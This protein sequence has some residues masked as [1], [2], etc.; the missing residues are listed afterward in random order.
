MIRFDDKND[1]SPAIQKLYGLKVVQTNNEFDYFSSN[2]KP[3]HLTYWFR[4]MATTGMPILQLEYKLNKENNQFVLFVEKPTI[5]EIP[6]TNDGWFTPLRFNAFSTLKNERIEHLLEDMPEIPHM[7]KFESLKQLVT[8]LYSNWALE[9]QQ[10]H[11]YGEKIG[12]N[13]EFRIVAPTRKPLIGLEFK[14]D[15]TGYSL[16][17]QYSLLNF[18]E[19]Y[20]PQ[21]ITL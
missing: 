9:V 18:E 15:K 4:V 7:P 2:P 12:G 13:I 11:W 10:L 3:N 17:R 6:K 5:N 14:T 1:I 20:N 21:W 8:W 19:K 16:I